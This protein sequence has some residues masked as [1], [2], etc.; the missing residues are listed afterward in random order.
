MPGKGLQA[1]V[2]FP[3]LLLLLANII[4]YREY[5][6]G[7]TIFNG[8]DLLTAF[9]PLL[10]FQTDC[11]QAR[12]L[13]LW[14]PFLNFGYPFVEHYSNTMFFPTHLLMGLLTGST[15]QLIQREL[16]F[17][18][19]IG[20]LGVYLCA[21]E[22]AYSCTAG[23][24]AGL[25]YMF[26]G[27]VMALPH[28]H[29]LVYNAAC[30]PYLLLGYHR[31]L[32]TGNSLSLVSVLF[33]AFS[34]FGG[35]ITT[36]VLGMYI[37]AAYVI[38]DSL[39]RKRF[40]FGLR[41]L[42]LTC[43]AGCLIALPKLWPM[44][45]SMAAG[46]RML[47]PESL[48][49]KDAFNTIGPYQFMSCLL[50]VKYFFSLYIGELGILA[51]VFAA[52]RRKLR[53]DAL[54]ILFLLTAWLLMVDGEGNVSILRSAA[55]ILPVMK[56]VRNEWFEWFYP[57]FFAIMWL[58][59]SVDRFLAE[60]LGRDHLIA[61]ACLVGAISVVFFSSFNRELYAAAY[62]VQ[63]ALVLAFTALPLLWDRKRIQLIA[64]VLLITTEF[65]LVL[66]RVG[67]DEPPLTDG[68]RVRYTV[69]D[70]ASVPR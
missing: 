6:T 33:L 43:L 13:P 36:T 45:S 57:S 11:L 49:T 61:A 35:H 68:A 56:L 70:Q 4:V 19:F 58:A 65:A 9:G 16:L 67:I 7:D 30:F 23:V 44:A 50:P 39:L 69:V 12:S 40:I 41:Y 17:W 42:A 63:L 22:L 60:R 10:N 47:A 29:L 2:V 53:A 15:M 25:S 59:G 51:L 64:A 28:W 3:V 31:S 27:Q 55:N 8:K 5:W 62:G 24:I 21:R 32:R 66:N 52:V 34:I 54:M 20:G 46:P 1:G 38:V 14:N 48:H 26:C 18:I 37:F